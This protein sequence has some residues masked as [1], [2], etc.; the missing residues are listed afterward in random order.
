MRRNG[1]EWAILTVSV[2]VVVALVGYLV[3][4][5]LSSAGPAMIE[6]HVAPQEATDGPDGA[7]LVPLTV[8]NSGG[9]AAVSIVVEGT[10]TVDGTE[11]ASQVTVDVLAADSEVGLVLG[12]SGRPEGEVA[13]RV[14]GFE[15]P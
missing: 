7:W 3:I 1:L 11:E 2:A 14:V 13:L 4:A 15:I 5:G 12:F 8:R 6:A 9:G 10:A